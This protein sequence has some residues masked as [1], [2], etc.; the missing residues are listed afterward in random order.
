MNGLGKVG[1]LVGEQSNGC[2][3]CN[4]W[5]IGSYSTGTVL[6]GDGV[7]VGGLVG[8]NDGGYIVESYAT[9]AV[10]GGNNAFVGGLTGLNDINEVA[11]HSVP[12]IYTSYSTGSVT[13]GASALLGGLIGNDLAQT[14]ITDSY[15]DMDTSGISDPSKG[16]GNIASD[17]GITGLTTAQFKSGLPQ[18]FDKKIWK[19][20]TPIN[21]GYPYLIDLPPG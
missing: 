16:A 20:K 3:G 15:W 1:G 6:G 18:G 5:T 9:G 13:G 2:D 8:Q 11:A 21:N 12:V 14:G 7:I 10:G 4:G 19:E 17:P